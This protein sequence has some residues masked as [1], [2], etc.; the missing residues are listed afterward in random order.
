MGMPKIT[1]VTN[2]NGIVTRH[3]TGDPRVSIIVPARNE[4]ETMGRR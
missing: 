3:A 1:D 4:E 2:Q